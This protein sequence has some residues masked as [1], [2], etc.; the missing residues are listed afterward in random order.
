LGVKWNNSV[1]VETGKHNSE[2]I[3]SDYFSIFND[4]KFKMFFGPEI[5]TI[6]FLVYLV[7]DKFDWEKSLAYEWLSGLVLGHL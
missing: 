7:V 4:D 3:L 1:S 2:N 5:T 6:L